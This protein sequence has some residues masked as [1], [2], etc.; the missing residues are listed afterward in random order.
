LKLGTFPAVTLKQ[1]HVLAPK[2]KGEI[3]TDHDPAAERRA[4]RAVSTNTVAALADDYLKRHTRKFKRFA[5]EDER[6]LNVDV[7]PTWTIAYVCCYDLRI[8]GS[9]VE[10]RRTDNGP[11]A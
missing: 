10:P 8:Y 4:A 5:A 1:A 3:D 6:L 2:A 11:G 9:C 7:L